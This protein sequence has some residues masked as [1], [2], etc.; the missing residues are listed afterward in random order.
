MVARTVL[1]LL[2]GALASADFYGVSEWNE[3]FGESGALHVIRERFPEFAKLPVTPVHGGWD[4]HVF[5]VGEEWVI[6]IPRRGEVERALRRE[7]KLLEAVGPRLPTR[8]PVPLRISGPSPIAVVAPRIRGLPA[9][10]RPNTARQ[11]GVFLR[12]LHGTPVESVPLAP[13]GIEEWRDAH[14]RRCAEFERTVFPLLQPDERNRAKAMFD[15]VIFDFRPV[16]VH[17]DLGPEHVLADSDGTVNGVID[18]GDARSG[19]P[20]I[21]LAWPLNGMGE[22]FAAAVLSSYGDVDRSFLARAA[23][24]HQRSPWYEVLY[25]LERKRDDLVASG[26]AGV[27][28]RL[29]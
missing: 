12:V 15:A 20:A 13:R 1:S 19:D 27:R 16:I 26:L 24:Y 28:S 7:A 4:S 29:P 17:G 18:W 10:D 11:L 14:A 3:E 22:S 21:D 8:V 5:F 2:D 23:F 9:A 25:G 6:R